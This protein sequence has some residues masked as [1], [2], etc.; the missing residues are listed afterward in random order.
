MTQRLLRRDSKKRPRNDGIE[1]SD[2]EIASGGVSWKEP[3][4][5]GIE[6]S[7][8]EIASGGVSWKEPRNDGWGI[9]TRRLL[10]GEFH[11]RILATTGGG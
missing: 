7:D 9:V 2:T 5:D 1:Y 6:D 10:R 4:N 3:R 8:T 11:G